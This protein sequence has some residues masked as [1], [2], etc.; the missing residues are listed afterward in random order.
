MLWRDKGNAGAARVIAVEF[1][2]RAI[3][4]AKSGNHESDP[5]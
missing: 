2:Q 4:K 3:F 5:R 1:G